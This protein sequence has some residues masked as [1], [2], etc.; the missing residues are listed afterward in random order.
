MFCIDIKALI[1]IELIAKLN[2]SKTAS[3]IYNSLPI[4]SKV[5]LWG[6]EIYFY[7]KAKI[8]PENPKSFVKVGDIA[9]WPGISTNSAFCIF[10]G[11]TPVSIDER[12]KPYSPV[13]VFGRVV[14]GLENI[15]RIKS[16]SKIKVERLDPLNPRCF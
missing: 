10:F 14:S 2:N 15:K 11:R 3:I 8:P 12:P 4:N 16:N 9:Y 6:D 5:N 1:G 13:N 7:I